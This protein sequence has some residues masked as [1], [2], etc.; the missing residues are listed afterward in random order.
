MVEVKAIVCPHLGS[1]WFTAD[2]PFC[3][4]LA[5]FWFSSS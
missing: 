3:L 2:V 1:N 5:A 4:Q